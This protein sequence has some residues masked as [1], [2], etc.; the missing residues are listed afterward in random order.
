MPESVDFTVLPDVASITDG[1]GA[2]W[3]FRYSDHALLKNGAHAGISNVLE[4][5]YIAHKVWAFKGTHWRWWDTSTSRWKDRG[6]MFETGLEASFPGIGG[7]CYFPTMPPPGFLTTFG[8]RG[9]VGLY[10]LASFAGVQ[11][12]A[13]ADIQ[14]A[15]NANPAGTTYVLAIGTYSNQTL[16]PKTGDR[17]IGLYNG[18]NGAVLDG[19][20]TTQFAVGTS[21]QY[22]T[23]EN[24]TIKNYTAPTQRGMI[25][26]CGPYLIV[27]NCDIFGCTGGA[28]VN[29]LDYALITH[30]KIH[31]NNQQAYSV[32]GDSFNSYVPI[33]G[34]LFDSNEMNNNNPTAGTWSGSEQGGGKTLVTEDL[35]FWFNWSHSNNGSLHWSDYNNIRTLFWGGRLGGVG[36]TAWNGIEVE[37]SQ[38]TKI[39]YCDFT[40]INAGPGGLSGFLSASA[41]FMGNSGGTDGGLSEF[42]HNT[43]KGHQYGRSLT[44]RMQNRSLQ[45]IHGVAGQ[46][47]WIE[48]TVVHHN[49]ID[50]S[51][52]T[53]VTDGHVGIASDNG[54]DIIFYGEGSH[55]SIRF[56][57]N[58]YTMGTVFAPFIWGSPGLTKGAWQGYGHDAHSTFIVTPETLGWSNYEKNGNVAI[59]GAQL[60]ATANPAGNFQ[61]AGRGTAET[62]ITGTDRKYFEVT[63]TSLSGA[64]PYGAAVGL[65][66]SAAGFGN[67]AA[68]GHDSHSLAYWP[69]GEVFR[70]FAVQFTLSTFAAGA[71]IGVAVDRALG[72][73]WLRKDAGAWGPSGD[74][75]AGTGGMDISTMGDV[76]PAYSIF[77]PGSLTLNAGG[78]AFAHA[79]PAGFV[80][81]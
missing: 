44:G 60:V 70:F 79:A 22:V 81:I 32:H 19:T 3:T 17:I 48:N 34:V 28:G 39:L 51:A 69:T 75:A 77:P 58:T 14:A 67:D 64:G 18:T 4:A 15:I 20:S 49:N 33:H 21:A 43:I 12:A 50:L 23:I 63:I 25:E 59:S 80:H 16:V 68:I 35:T 45:D 24:V 29:V 36:E 55:R 8:L 41:I 5:W 13:G 61:Q 53:S 71:V 40:D 46:P 42:A 56:D 30:N 52:S 65:S 26:R 31:D 78:T 57:Y 47:R 27:K 11:I 74:P 6:A 9:T 2:V 73:A 54:S 10:V 72:K 62:V 37:I 1:D 38:T 7:Q 66:D 76:Y